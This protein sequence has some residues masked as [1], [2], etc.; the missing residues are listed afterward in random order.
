MG[1]FDNSGPFDGLFDLNNDGNLDF[2]ETAQRDAFFW[3]DDGD[4]ADRDE[5]DFENNEWNA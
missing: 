5:D 2:L 3:D 4:K 1:F